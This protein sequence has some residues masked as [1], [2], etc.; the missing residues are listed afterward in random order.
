MKNLHG[1]ARERAIDEMINKLDL[2]EQADKEWGLEDLST[3]ELYRMNENGEDYVTML[4]FLYLVN[5]T[6]MSDFGH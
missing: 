4:N 6:L 3:I 5:F 1:Y 2:L